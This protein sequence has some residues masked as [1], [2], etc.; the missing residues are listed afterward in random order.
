MKM[1]YLLAAAFVL[2]LPLEVSA[3]SS[4]HIT[5]AVNSPDRPE[6]ETSR[7]AKRKPGEVLSFIGIE[8]GMKVADLHGGS[9]Y[10]TDLFSRAVGDNGS[11]M[12]HINF[13]VRGRFMNAF[14][15]GGTLEKRAAGK[16]WKKNVT[17]KYNDMEA[18]QSEKPLDVAFMGL[19]YHDTVW[20]GTE[21][22]KMNKAVFNALKPGG[23]YVIIDHAAEKGSGIRDVKTLHRIDK[24][25]VIQE[26]EAAGFK[27][28]SESDLLANPA[29]THDFNVFRDARTNRDNTDRFLLKFQK[30][31]R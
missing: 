22:D 26:I 14:G 20:Q 5:A 12:N 21:R 24:K 30:P 29:D 28:I 18:I 31:A 11:V 25:L 19:F 15:P 9:G 27:L 23:L 7:D 16:Q 17:I 3:S 8:P 1:K 2:P 13:Y 10:Y 4:T 6:N